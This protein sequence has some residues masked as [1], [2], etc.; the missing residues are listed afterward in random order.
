MALL[1]SAV[2]GLITR[3]DSVFGDMARQPALG[4]GRFATQRCSVKVA[5]N[6]SGPSSA[7]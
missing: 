6:S 4:G 7:I 2:V 1:V 3:R 5:G